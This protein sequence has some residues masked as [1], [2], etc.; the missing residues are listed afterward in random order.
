MKEFGTFMFILITGVLCDILQAF[1][2]MKLWLW[3]IVS[4]FGLPGLGFIQAFGLFLIIGFVNKKIDYNEKEF[5]IKQFSGK[6]LVVI[7]YSLIAL[8]TGWLVTLFYNHYNIINHSQ[9]SQFRNYNKN[10]LSNHSISC[11]LPT[12]Y[13]LLISSWISSNSFS[14]LVASIRIAIFLNLLIC[15]CITSGSCASFICSS[16]LLIPAVINFS[17]VY[18]LVESCCILVVYSATLARSPPLRYIS[19]APLLYLLI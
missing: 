18:F 6:T 10:S 17:M 3:F 7:I 9:K 19:I 1:V 2:F 5:G 15:C 11:F 13:Y 12:A 8:S 14:S 4:T 16:S